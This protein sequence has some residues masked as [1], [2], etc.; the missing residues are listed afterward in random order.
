MPWRNW[1]LRTQVAIIAGVL[2]A[3]ACVGASALVIHGVRGPAIADLRHKVADR[4]LVVG[5][6]AEQGMLPPV[7]PIQPIPAVQVV[8]EQTGRILSSTP[9]LVGRPRLSRL[10]PG[11]GHAM[12]SAEECASATLQD[13]CALVVATRV[14]SPRGAVLVYGFDHSVPWYVTPWLLVVLLMGSLAVTGAAAYL[15]RRFVEHLLRPVRAVRDKLA[16]VTADEPSWSSA[17][18]PSQEIGDLATSVNVTLDKLRQSVERQRRFASDA[19][20]DL[21]SPITAMRAQIE[22]GLLHPADT[23]WVKTGEALMTSLDR[24][25]AIVTDLLL[26]ARL[27]AGERIVRGYLDLSELVRTEL[28]HRTRRRRVVLGLEPGVVVSGDRLQLARLLT[29]LL[30]NAERHATSTVTVLVRHRNGKAVLEVVDDGD[31]IPAD[32]REVVFQRFTRLPAGR[33]KDQQG[34]GLGLA[35]AR[36]IAHRHNGTL[37]LE[38]SPAGARFVLTVP[39]LTIHPPD[40]QPPH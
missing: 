25:Q 12:A 39:L 6:G 17:A 1:S 9:A 13:G 5:Y 23:N 31:G 8:D 2:T 28:N 35:I 27:D 11:L 14:P 40:G 7:L 21:R 20:H 4:T 33:A 19:S 36:E 34:T 10:S 30:D 29:N 16:E 15:A 26:I 18:T 37:R 38:D 22:E 24:L 3:L 32:Q